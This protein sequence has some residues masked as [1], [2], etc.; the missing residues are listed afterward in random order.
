MPSPGILADIGQLPVEVVAPIFE[1]AQEQSLILSMANTMPLS[2]GQTNIPVI[3]QRPEAG[4]VGESERKPGSEYRYEMR[5]VTPRKFATIVTVS[6]EFMDADIAGLYSQIQGDLSFA[7]ARAVDLA[8][9]HGRAATTGDALAGVEGQFLNATDNRV[10]L[11]TALPDEGGLAKDIGDG[12]EL[13]VDAGH[14][15]T[16]F[17]ADPRFRARAV[18]A[19]DSFG[20]P[21]FQAAGPDLS[22]ATMT[23]MGLPV[24]Y[25]RAVSGKIGANHDTRVRAIGGD[26]NQLRVGIVKD[27]RLDFTDSASITLGGQLVSLWENNLVALRAEIIFGWAIGDLEAFAAYEDAPARS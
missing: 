26:F 22:D 15:F 20:R 9:L 24:R 8:V 6:Q 3:T 16:S 17:A 19:Y 25:G 11:G 14:D 21:L 1:K 2:Y 7:I 18:N 23:V 13:V 12:Y 27:L 10:T 4:P 5:V